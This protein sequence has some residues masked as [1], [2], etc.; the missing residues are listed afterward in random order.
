MKSCTKPIE[1]FADVGAK[2]IFRPGN[3]L[4]PVVLGLLPQDFDHV[5]FRAIGW[6]VAEKGVEFLHPAQGE[7]VAQPM[8]NARIV[9]NDQCRHGLGDPR[10]Q[11]LHE[12]D[13]GFAVYR[14]S[15]L[16]VIEPLPGE[17]QRAHHGNALMRY[18]GH[19]MRTAQ[20]RPGALYRRRGRE[21]GFVVV[22]QLATTFPCPRLQTGKF[23]G[24][25]G[26]SF[27]VAVFFKLMRVRLK[28]NP[29]LFRILPKRSSEIGKDAP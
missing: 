8:M 5:Q 22:D 26:K 29:W 15:S 18:R 9:E 11:V 16:R 1:Q 4:A 12:I 13:E 27:R 14:G 7:A 23:A 28:L 20:R 17:V 3:E 21:A 19:R 24:A 10:D 2:G 6:Q 25:G